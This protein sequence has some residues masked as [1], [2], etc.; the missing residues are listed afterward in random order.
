[1]VKPLEQQFLERYP[2]LE[3]AHLHGMVNLMRGLQPP[4]VHEKPITD[5]EWRELGFHP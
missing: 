3:L 5:S 2:T 1:M 4:T